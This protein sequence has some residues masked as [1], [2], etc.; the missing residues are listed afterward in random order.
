[1]KN[2]FLRPNYGRSK[3]FSHLVYVFDFVYYRSDEPVNPFLVNRC[4]TK[5]AIRRLS[6]KQEVDPVSRLHSHV[7]FRPGTQTKTNHP[8]RIQII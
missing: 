5:N 1:M 2:T 3:N 8:D 4:Y 6:K 7:N